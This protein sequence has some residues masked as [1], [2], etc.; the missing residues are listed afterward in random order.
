MLKKIINGRSPNIF[1]KKL[2]NLRVER[3]FPRGFERFGVSGKN[4]IGVEIGVFEGEHAL[5]LIKN[6]NLKKLYLI[7]PYVIHD[8]YSPEWRKSIIQAQREVYEL[9]K[10][11]SNVKVIFKYSDEALKEIGEKVDFVYIDGDHS[12]EA[13]KKDINNYWKIVKDGGL[14]GGHDVH[15][16]V[17]P[18]NR[19]VMKAVFEFAL[20][21]KLDVVIQGED[22]WVKKPLP[23]SRK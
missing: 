12:Y 18:H 16:A 4:L 6:L 22:W 2:F 13:V 8:S 15:N 17:R 11:H 3:V 23:K 14:L 7:D 20:S 1:L 10:K 9:S 5:S 19:G 21:E